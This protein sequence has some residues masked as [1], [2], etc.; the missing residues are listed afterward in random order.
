MTGNATMTGRATG[1]LKKV[2]PEK[3]V[4]GHFLLLDGSIWTETMLYD[5][6]ISLC[7]SGYP[8]CL[9]SEK[10]DPRPPRGHKK[11]HMAARRAVFWPLG[12]ILAR[13]S[14]FCYSTPDFVNGPFVTLDDI[15]NLAPSDRFLVAV[16]PLGGPFSGHRAGFWPENPFFA[17][18]PRI[19]SMARL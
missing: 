7:R 5:Q 16:R 3:K 14:V 19:L 12:R 17:I 2:T 18:G 8:T 15:F 9:Y 10:I 6:G 4:F 1:C 11:G 13:K